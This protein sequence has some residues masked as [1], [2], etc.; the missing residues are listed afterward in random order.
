[1]LKNEGFKTENDLETGVQLDELGIY[2]RC[3]KLNLFGPLLDT[4]IDSPK[5]LQKTKRTNWSIALFLP[6]KKQSNCTK[7]T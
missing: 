1:M 2:S 7:V 3:S 4:H 5:N 6:A